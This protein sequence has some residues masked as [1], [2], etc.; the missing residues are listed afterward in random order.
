MWFH[1]KDKEP[2]KPAITIVFEATEFQQI[3]DFKE[4]PNGH[5][6]FEGCLQTVDEI[7]RNTKCYPQAVLMEA[8]TQPRIQELLKRNAWIGEGSHPWDRKNFHRSIDVLPECVTHRV[9]TMPVLRG[10]QLISTIHTIEP[11]GKTVDSWIKDEQ[12]QT[13]VKDIAQYHNK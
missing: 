5:L 8:L 13:G 4:L 3:I 9:C 12:G 11:C 6:E 10:N 7:N 1:S 2:E